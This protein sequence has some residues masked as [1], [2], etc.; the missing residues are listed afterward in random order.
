M[1]ICHEAVLGE[2]FHFDAEVLHHLR[3]F[4]EHFAEVLKDV[5]RFRE[6][7]TPASRRRVF[8]VRDHSRVV[9]RLDEGDERVV[10]VA[11][12]FSVQGGFDQL[13]DVFP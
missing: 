11:V 12:E 13:L 9:R 8:G 7:R 6:R 2:E 4:V 1:K 3:K 5:V 10:V